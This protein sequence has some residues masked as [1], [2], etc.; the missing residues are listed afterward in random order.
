MTSISIRLLGVTAASLL[1][2]AA[3][4]QTPPATGTAGSIDNT[5][6]GT[7]AADLPHGPIVNGHNLQPRPGQP[8]SKQQAN[9]VN[10]LLQQ[11]PPDPAAD[12]PIVQPRDLYG[13]PIGGSPGLDQKKP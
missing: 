6:V 8:P 3:L 9:Q 13:N 4:A 1:A 7:G 2:G 11:T 10:Q 12:G 5:A